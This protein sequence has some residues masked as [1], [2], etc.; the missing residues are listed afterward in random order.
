M[1]ELTKLAEQHFRE[2]QSHLH[3][4][5]ELMAQARQAHAAL[6]GPLDLDA[7]LARIK[8]DRDQAAQE[9]DK[10]RQLP[11]AEWDKVVE[12]AAGMNGLLTRIGQQLDDVLAT[13]L[14]R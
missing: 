12:R 2:W 5:D 13:V 9:F 1:D 8:Q 6:P 11:T 3:H 4:I 14:S 10:I 7:R